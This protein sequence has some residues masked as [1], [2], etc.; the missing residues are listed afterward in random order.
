MGKLDGRVAIVTGASRGIGE[1]IARL[2]ASE[3][4]KHEEKPVRNEWTFAGA[5]GRYDNAQLRRGFHPRISRTGKTVAQACCRV[6]GAV[7]K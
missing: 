6:G 4:A 7:T 3:G 1:G 5:F 2:L